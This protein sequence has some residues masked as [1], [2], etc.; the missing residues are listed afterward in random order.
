[1]MSNVY[2]WTPPVDDVGGVVVAAAATPAR[3]A[4]NPNELLRWPEMELATGREP[5][6]T[7][8]FFRERARHVFH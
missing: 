8:L 2:V 7:L 1:M 3:L 5:R 6:R 4:P